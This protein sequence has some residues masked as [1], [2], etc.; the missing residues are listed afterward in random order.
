MLT[1]CFIHSD[2][3]ALLT[4]IEA[5][6]TKGSRTEPSEGQCPVVR[7]QV[8]VHSQVG[9]DP[10]V[11]AGG[12]DE[13]EVPVDPPE[14]RG[15]DVKRRRLHLQ[16]PGSTFPQLGKDRD[17]LPHFRNSRFWRLVSDGEQ[18]NVKL[19]PSIKLKRG[20]EEAGVSGFVRGRE[21]PSSDDSSSL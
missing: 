20:Y 9:L 5:G 4:I 6:A 14:G 3:C 16:T 17:S 13:A 1:S 19:R 15:A 10:A 18:V 21:A 7:L 8:P 2:F 11:E 12:A